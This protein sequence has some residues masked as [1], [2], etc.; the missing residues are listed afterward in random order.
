M[1]KLEKAPAVIFVT[2]RIKDKPSDA[3]LL[4]RSVE[5][6]KKSVSSEMQMLANDLRASMPAKRR[7]K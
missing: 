3:A 7:G 5:R 4:R 1:L 2:S 6:A